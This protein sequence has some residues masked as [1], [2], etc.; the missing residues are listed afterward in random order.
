M[1]STI[2]FYWRS[3]IQVRNTQSNLKISNELIGFYLYSAT[4]LQEYS[5]F[6][7][8]V[9]SPMV[10]VVSRNVPINP[11][12]GMTTRRPL[13]QQTIP[14]YGPSNDQYVSCIEILL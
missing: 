7:V 6:W 3:Y 12:Y 1:A 9:E 5:T 11:S 2:R 14:N 10:N 8:G 4:V 13:F